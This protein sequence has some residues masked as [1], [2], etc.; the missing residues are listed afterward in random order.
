MKP[1]QRP[2]DTPF[3]HEAR[4]SCDL[5]ERAAVMEYEGG[6]TREVAERKAWESRGGGGVVGRDMGGK[7]IASK[8]T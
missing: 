5:C 6:Y 8:E 4:C 3:P 1:A 2:E 7:T